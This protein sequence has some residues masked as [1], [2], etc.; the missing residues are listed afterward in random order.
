MDF[1]ILND[2]KYFDFFVL[3]QMIE[4]EPCFWICGYCK[5][6]DYSI[7]NNNIQSIKLIRL[8]S[9]R[10]LNNEMWDWQFYVGSQK[11]LIEDSQIKQALNN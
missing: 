7:S 2:D 6:E 3:G 11:D 10:Q 9:L 8:N 1:S 5:N 4:N